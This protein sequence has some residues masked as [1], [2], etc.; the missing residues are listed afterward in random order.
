VLG[1][2]RVGASGAGVV[3]ELLGVEKHATFLSCRLR[4]G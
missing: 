1:E 4:L 2:D 3:L